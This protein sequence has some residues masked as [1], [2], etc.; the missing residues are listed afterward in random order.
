[1][2]QMQGR[3]AVAVEEHFD[4]AAY[5]R[6][7]EYL[8]PRGYT[9]EYVTHLWGQPELHF[10]SKPE[11]GRVVEHVTVR[12]E[13]AGLPLEDYD[14]LV[15]IGGYAMD[16]LRYQTAPRKGMANRAPAF[17]VAAGK[18]APLRSSG[19]LRGD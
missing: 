14:A 19:Q 9:V 17:G 3:I 5:R 16:R 2:A 7:N 1:M 8:P 4:G 13:V 10:G 12:T 11:D 18:A 15:L 6:F